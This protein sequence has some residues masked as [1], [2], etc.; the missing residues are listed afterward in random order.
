MRLCKSA[1]SA[2]EQTGLDEARTEAR[3]SPQQTLDAPVPAFAPSALG[4]SLFETKPIVIARTEDEDRTAT[5]ESASPLSNGTSP[6]D[7]A[8]RNQ[9]HD[10]DAPNYQDRLSKQAALV[11]QHY[12]LSARETEVMELIARGNT[13]ARIAEQLVVSE[14]TIRTQQA[15]LRQA[16][17][18]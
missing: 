5:G 18:P 3:R 16:G 4:P 7:T 8:K 10:A 9:A 1:I 11:G 17:Y 12:R 14:N 2:G 6:A 15:H 13:V